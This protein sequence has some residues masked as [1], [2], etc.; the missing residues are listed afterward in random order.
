MK[1]R[2]I[3]IEASSIPNESSLPGA[4]KDVGDIERF[5]LSNLGGAWYSH[6]ITI[7]RNPTV[8]QVKSEIALANSADYSFV[9]FSGHG[10]H[11]QSNSLKEDKICLYNGEIPTRELNSGSRRTTIMTDSC[12]QIVLLEE[13]QEFANSTM[14]KSAASSDSEESRRRF[15]EAVEQC[16]A[17]ATYL[18]SCNL[19]EAA[20]EDSQGGLFTQ[21]MLESAIQAVSGRHSVATVHDVFLQASP[22]VTKIQPQQNPIF[23]GGRTL[24]HFPFAVGP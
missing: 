4:K 21:K 1:R 13:R 23:E 15:N 9:T 20:A 2:A 19:N 17:G 22:K 5:L 11:S 24:T 16:P 14:L 7:L 18:Y 12:R 6:E 8:S 3:L 10:Y